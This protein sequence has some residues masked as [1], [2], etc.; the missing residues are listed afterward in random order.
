MTPFSFILDWLQTHTSVLWWL[1]A[2]SGLTFFGTL[3]VIPI[4]VVR[5]PAD[6]FTCAY[7]YA[8]AHHGAW[9][10]C[11][12]VVKNAFGLLF[13]LTGIAMLVLPGQGVL[14]ILIGIMLMN[15]PRKRALELRIVQQPTVL[16]ALNWMR[17]NAKRPALIVHDTLCRTSPADDRGETRA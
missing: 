16:R 5:I 11:G 7:R 3:I 2:L 1:G 9:Y 15:F 14:T 17:A 13:I 12:L 4:L 6:Y 8:H 10:Y